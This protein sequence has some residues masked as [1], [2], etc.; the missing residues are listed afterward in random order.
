MTLHEA[1]KL[2][3]QENKAPMKPQEVLD[4]I[5]KKKLYAKKDDSEI[6]INQI[7]ARANNYPN[8]FELKEG[9]IHLV[10]DTYSAV[11][12]ILKKI[13][14]FS[15]H[16]PLLNF[17]L[18]FPFILIVA[19][20]SGKRFGRYPFNTI[21]FVNLPQLGEKD[22]HEALSDLCDKL[23][24]DNLLGNS[25]KLLKGS[26]SDSHNSGLK[27]LLKLTAEIDIETLSEK[28][29]SEIIDNYLYSYSRSKYDNQF[30][31]PLPLVNYF[32]RLV[33]LT[34]GDYLCDPFA[35]DGRLANELIPKGTNNIKVDLIEL[36][37][38]SV[39]LGRMRILINQFDNIQYIEGNSYELADTLN[40]RYNWVVSNPPFGNILSI[41]STKDIFSGR[42]EEKQIIKLTLS[43]LNQK[44]KAALLLPEGFF[45]N[46]S[47][48]SVR[49]YLI[50]KDLIQEIHSLPAGVLSPATEIKTSILLLNKAKPE[51]LKNKINFKE[52]EPPDLKIE[53]P[54]QIPLSDKSSVNK[55]RVVNLDEV[56]NNEW[57][58]T[59][60]R[61]LNV[62]KFDAN[63]IELR[64]VIK[65]FRQ[66]SSIQKQDLRKKGKVPFIQIAQLSDSEQD[67]NLHIDNAKYFAS[68]K[69]NY[70]KDLID[71]EMVLLAKVGA[72]IKPTY[73]DGSTPILIASNI[74]GFE[75][76]KNKILTKYLIH[77]LQQAYVK[78]Q[79][80][81]IRGGTVYSF[82]RQKDL[83]DIRIKVP[84]IIVQKSELEERYVQFSTDLV[85]RE[86]SI[87]ADT[88][89]QLLSSIK[90]E[91]SNLKTIVDGD[92]FLLKSFLERKIELHD[93]LSWN[94]EISIM[95]DSRKLNQLFSNIQNTLAQMGAVFPTLQ[96]IMDFSKIKMQKEPVSIISFIKDQVELLKSSLSGV[97]VYYLID[98]FPALK[99]NDIVINLDKSQFATV[100]QNFLFNSVKHAFE[101]Q[102]ELSKTICFNV[103]QAE[104][105]LSAEIIMMNNGKP[106][107]DNF[108]IEDF[109][110]FGGKTSS[111]GTGIGGYLMNR[112]IENHNG[113][114]ELLDISKTQS[115]F[116][117]RSQIELYEKDTDF[118]NRDYAKEYKEYI[119]E[120][121]FE[122]EKPPLASPLDF[123]VFVAFHPGIAFKITIPVD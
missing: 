62:F 76:D 15:V 3:L 98:D 63:Y 16:V 60:N 53:D 77:E 114:L 34:S 69:I 80:D 73:Y 50:Q 96:Q 33:R 87:K 2:I 21:N 65:N 66:G 43:L 113:T 7:Y 25:A 68:D 100:I 71:R 47:F 12:T 32:K 64:S 9:R 24:T 56:K 26:I 51:S 101:Q 20:F 19:R 17:D 122:N 23:K 99:K 31:T 36:N 40:Q 58:L 44:G 72:K 85:K 81:R 107:K 84:P 120:D 61:Y 22:A 8:L 49:E 29:F 28:E 59:A 37:P 38:K 4:I 74:V 1:I 89:R 86:G 91:F 78:E 57:L 111:S 115:Y 35:S 123:P 109:V 83:L 18:L 70:S 118:N 116:I 11:E 93:K 108:T 52:V 90:H 121:F 5:I 48:E 117:D 39:L 46:K 110:S 54:D 75:V 10:K 88:E 6:S 14:N 67:I 94:D 30:K 95:P 45:F 106:M 104:D 55:E 82:V 42:E 102:A 105:H 79:F 112:V 92:I 27:N 13:R 103:N 119:I 97:S 41:E